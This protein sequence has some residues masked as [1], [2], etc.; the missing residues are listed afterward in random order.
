M[1]PLHLKG[2]VTIKGIV[3]STIYILVII[4]SG[5]ICFIALRT[6]SLAK[7]RIPRNSVFVSPVT[8]E[9]VTSV[10]TG[11]KPI[12]VTY[13][14]VKSS[15]ALNG[16]SN[17]A[18]IYEYIDKTGKPCY[19]ALFHDKAPGKSSSMTSIESTS[20]RHLP[21]FNFIELKNLPKDYIRP[22]R[23]VFVNLGNTVFSNF[24]YENGQYY[25]Y[26]DTFKDID[27]AASKQVAVSNIIVQFIGEGIKVDSPYIEGSGKALLFSG[28]RVIDIKWDKNKNKPIKVVDEEGKPI[29]L[30]KGSTW[31]ILTPENSSVAYN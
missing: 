21:K 23:S 22:A 5:M 20:D 28:G 27:K 19:K 8:G 10:S 11:I 31:W 13:I 30:L 15:T 9:R 24:L 29:S 16:I 25:H 6:M 4:L 12:E 14:P 3:N 1:V 17:A 18:L 2:G 7:A 26:R